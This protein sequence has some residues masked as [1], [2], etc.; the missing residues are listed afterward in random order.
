M[1]KSWGQRRA[2]A[3]TLHQQWHGKVASDIRGGPFPPDRSSLDRL[4]QLHQCEEMDRGGPE[5]T[6]H[7]RLRTMAGG[8]ESSRGMQHGTANV[9]APKAAG[10]GCLQPGPVRQG[11]TSDGFQGFPHG[12]VKVL[13]S[14]SEIGREAGTEDIGNLRKGKAGAEESGF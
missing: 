7:K 3:G 12:K 14:L 9:E 10:K 1:N 6:F 5:H 11:N 2:G 13:G 8:K 4:L